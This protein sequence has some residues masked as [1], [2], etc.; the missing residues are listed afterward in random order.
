MVLVL[1]Y[2][3]YV[4][5]GKDKTNIEFQQ[6]QSQQ[7]IESQ[8]QNLEKKRITKDVEIVDLE[9]IASRKTVAGGALGLGLFLANIEQIVAIL[10]IPYESWSTKHIIKFGLLALSL[11]LQVCL[12]LM[13]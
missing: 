6:V 1:R 11:V 8:E 13:N 2:W 4:D 10:D 7:Q 5:N 9:S 12:F 3:D